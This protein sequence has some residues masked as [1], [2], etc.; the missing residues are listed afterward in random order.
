MSGASSL[1]D[2]ARGLR[3]LIESEADLIEE[4]NTMT[5]A[6]VDAPSPKVRLASVFAVRCLLA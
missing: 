2:R 6:I 1:L 5:P 3:K 4:Q